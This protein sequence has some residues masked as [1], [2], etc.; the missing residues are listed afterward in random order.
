MIPGSALLLY[1]ILAALW[2]WGP[3]AAYFGVLQLFAFEPFH[4]PFLDIHAMLAAAQCYRLGVD[5]YLTN[6]C[7]ALG[8]VHVYSPLWLRI[9]PAFLDTSDTTIVGLGL[10]LLFTGSLMVVC[11]RATPIEALPIALTVMSPMTVYAVE[12][13]N[14]DL[15]V[16]LLI[17]AGC[18]LLQLCRSMRLVGYALF[19]FA[20]LLKYY[21][22]IL[23]LIVLRERRRDAIALASTATAILVLV[24]LRNHTE[25]AKALASIP[26]PSY[27]ADSFAAVNLPF[28]FAELL[29]TVPCRRTIA[30]L[31]LA[32]LTGLLAAKT[33]RS[34]AI[35][36]RAALNRRTFETNCTVVGALLLT[37]CFFAGQNI[38][39]RGVYFVLVMPGLL[40]L[41]HRPHCRSAA[42]AVVDRSGGAVRGLGRGLAAPR[43]R[44]DRL[45]TDRS[46]AGPRRGPVLARPRTRVVV[47]DR[48]A[49]RN[50][51]VV[52]A[53]A[54]AG[55]RRSRAVADIF[56][57]APATIALT[58][59]RRTR[60][61][62]QSRRH[63]RQSR[64]INAV[65]RRFSD[66]C[67]RVGP[68]AQARQCP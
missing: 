32:A 46:S 5:V 54:S 23:L 52:F 33:R 39:Y 41:P 31:L 14:N 8:R 45:H 6:P 36:G 11:R 1:S 53:A 29:P 50:R 7:D 28:G 21:P 65:A 15:I 57:I 20:G 61:S 25:I 2:L 22:L 34:L 35:V 37:A 67:Q 58:G 68:V 12:R 51:A 3:H 56:A 26:S 10:G 48:R 18:G 55:Q 30:L 24:V 59:A 19:F 17:L 27:F 40:Y 38:D 49:R 9:T 60:G 62:A 63:R 47:A 4:F 16:F 42:I 13:A 44:R 43:L 66:Q 64:D